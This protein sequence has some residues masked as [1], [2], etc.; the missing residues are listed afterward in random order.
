M[1]REEDYFR[2]DIPM[3][4]EDLLVMDKPN[5]PIIIHEGPFYL[6]YEGK[7]VILEGSIF[8]R[9]LPSPDIRFKAKGALPAKFLWEVMEKDFQTYLLI[10]DYNLGEIIVTVLEEANEPGICDVEGLFAGTPCK[11]D[12]QQQVDTV[13]FCLHNLKSFGT[14]LAKQKVDGRVRTGQNRIE[15][16]CAEY[17]ITIDKRNDFKKQNE[18]L[19]STGGFFVLY[20][21]EI[22]LKKAHSKDEVNDLCFALG[23]F[24]S[25][26]NGRRVHPIFL[27]GYKKGSLVWNYYPRAINEAFQGVNSW[28]LGFM[29]KMEFDHMWDRFSKLWEDDNSKDF[30]VFYIKWYCEA[31]SPELSS[32]TRLIMAQSILELVFNWWLV[33][34]AGLIQGKDAKFLDASNKIRLILSSCSM[35]RDIPENFKELKAV[36]K[37]QS[38]SDGPEAIV[39]V[40]NALV[41]ARQTNRE[42]IKKIG[43]VARM[44]ALQL[45]IFYGE[46][47]LLK[48]LNYGN[49]RFQNRCDHKAYQVPWKN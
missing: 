37:G 16:D 29:A 4:M 19:Q 15:L 36:M 39:H 9:W 35:S 17:K 45:A 27:H 10:G 7:K 25:F 26:I 43:G 32:D 33:E 23:M 48:I 8:Y 34:T 38:S 5:S 30:L 6:K 41:H 20:N 1:N 11:E 31:N 42:K 44:Q 12:E 22:Q 3:V 21:G 46:L 13:K 2:D 18:T 24:L 14:V 47:A 40:R 28:S 49:T